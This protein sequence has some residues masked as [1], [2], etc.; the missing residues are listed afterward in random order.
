MPRQSGFVVENNFSNGLITQ[1]TGL[2][3]P[4]NACTETYNCEF[5]LD[6]SVQR[7]RGIDK[8]TAFSTKN[9][10][11][12]NSAINSYVWRNVGGNGD[13]TLV[14]MQV[15]ATIY[16]YR[17]TGSSLSSGAVSTTV[18]LT[19][20]SGA[21]SVIA[22]EA[23]FSDG[24][25]Y[26]FV[27]HPF[28]EPMRVSYNT[29]SDTATA[30]NITIK[31]RDFEGDT[32]DANAI[33]TRPTATLAGLN[34]AHKYNLYNQGWTTT[35]LTAWDTSQTT[36]P[37]NV[38]VMWAFKNSSDAFDMAT[39]N[40]VVRGNTPAPKGHYIVTLSNFDRDTT[41]GLSGV[42]N[43]TTSYYRPTTSCFFA[44]RVFYSG[45][46]YNKF[47]SSIYFTQTIERDEQYGF[48][49]QV[50]DPTAEDQFDLLPSDGGVI[51]IQ[52]AGT[53]YKL[54]TVPG[55]IAVFAANGVWF[56]T[57]SSGI[58]FTA[59]DYTVQKISTIP[60]LNASSFVD[61]AGMPA[62]WNAEGIYALAGSEGGGMPQVQSLTDAKIKYFYDDIPLASKRA[63]KG[64]YDRL[65]K[66]VQWIFKS[67]DT[68]QTTNVYEYDRILNFN[69]LTGAFYPWTISSSTA[70][71]HG[72]V[73]G[74]VNSGVTTV[75]NVIDGSSNN[76]ID[77]STNQIITFTTS[78]ASTNPA[79]KYIMSSASG[80]TYEFT[81]ADESSSNYLDW[82]QHT[83][84]GVDYDSYFITG[85]RTRGDAIRDQ[86]TNWVRVHSRTLEEVKY[87]FQA[88]WDW[89]V[90]GDTGRWSSRQY[91][92]EDDTNYSVRSKRLK[93]RGHGKTMQFMI[94]S[95]TGEPFDLL[96]WTSMDMVNATP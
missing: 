18:T 68:S 3:F 27:T 52:E 55:G 49:Y 89:S 38:D 88:I 53:I 92:V 86:Q 77:A 96:G 54:F 62:W 33:D 50:N 40:N 79:I 80:S 2:N 67:E 71:I 85:Y 22:T 6:G 42:T 91:V 12:S 8:E 57:G 43:S 74:D 36:M 15:G 32:A 35:N 13:V 95:V 31:V 28:C 17:T 34:V 23:Q 30:T 4:E 64:I 10:D 87:Y 60:A 47:N 69:T 59:A 94:T 73:L 58:G 93:V 14:V 26:L 46:P 1:A 70:K 11:R 29:S 39:L 76:V 81:F 44:G 83:T 45:I 66:R 5:S 75:D 72:L 63:A 78:S 56:V 90:T 19:A 7:R 84:T 20:V 82:I 41:S 25:G 61:I 37:S 16:F 21:P 51:R 9:I 48:C 65:S 24:N